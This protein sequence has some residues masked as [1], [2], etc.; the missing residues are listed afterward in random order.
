MRVGYVT[1]TRLIGGI[2]FWRAMRLKDKVALVTG[3][4]TGIGAA[5]TSAFLR[6]GAHVAIGS[7]SPSHY[8]EAEKRFRAM[9][10][11]VLAL[12][13]DVTD[14]RGVEQFVTEVTR[15]LGPIDILVN[16]AGVSGQNPIDQISDD[17]W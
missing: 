4:G 15:S 12:Q 9:G 14:Q 5:I 6:E 3:G 13:L 1:I 7:R 10:F 17:R 8:K 11:S 2:D 16:N